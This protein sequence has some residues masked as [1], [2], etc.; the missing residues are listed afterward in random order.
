MKLNELKTIF[1]E[2]DDFKEKINI[3]VKWGMSDKLSFETCIFVV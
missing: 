2:I 1:T 3:R